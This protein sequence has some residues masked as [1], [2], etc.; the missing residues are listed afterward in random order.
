[1][2]KV[3]ITRW[4]RDGD[5]TKMVLPHEVVVEY[6]STRADVDI[7][8]QFNDNNAQTIKII[9]NIIYIKFINK[10]TSESYV[11]EFNTKFGVN[12][13][14]FDNLKNYSILKKLQNG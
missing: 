12:P 13:K 5:K 3:I 4:G 2:K 10:L 6:F 14:I 8:P 11:R 9:D 1:M 7:R